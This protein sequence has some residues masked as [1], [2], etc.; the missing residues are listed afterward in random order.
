MKQ[1]RL[2]TNPRHRENSVNSGFHAVVMVVGII[3]A[4][5][6][7]NAFSDALDCTTLSGYDSSTPADSTDQAKA[8]LDTKSNASIEKIQ[9]ILVFVVYSALFLYSSSLGSFRLSEALLREASKRI[10]LR[11]TMWQ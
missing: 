9:L 3:I 6:I 4:L 8:C 10:L 5:I 2:S 11:T 7:F 1:N